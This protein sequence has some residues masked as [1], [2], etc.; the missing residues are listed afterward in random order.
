MLNKSFGG[1]YFHFNIFSE[2]NP[3]K[4]VLKLTF[5][6]LENLA[7]GTPLYITQKYIQIERVHPIVFSQSNF[8]QTA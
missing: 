6:G 5:L 8:L 3:K 7:Q 4:R 2:K 1:I